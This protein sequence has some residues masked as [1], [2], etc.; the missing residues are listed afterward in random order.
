LGS[1]TWIRRNP[2]KD[3]AVGGEKSLGGVHKGLLDAFT[4]KK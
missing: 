1:V 2:K 4:L 3:D